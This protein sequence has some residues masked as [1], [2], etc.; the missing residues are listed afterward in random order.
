MHLVNMDVHH[1]RASAPTHLG[2]F[3]PKLNA[4]FGSPGSGKSLLLHW[5]RQ[6]AAAD[7]AAVF[8]HPEH[9]ATATD[10][11]A[12]SAEIVSRGRRYRVS[13]DRPGRPI[14]TQLSSSY[15][16]SH[17]A[18]VDDPRG[19]GSIVGEAEPLS[20][21]QR[22]V[23][24]AVTQAPDY[25]DTEEA[26]ASS[27]QRLQLGVSLPAG[28]H[29]T[30]ADLL[31]RQKQLELLLGQSRLASH[32]SRDGL[33]R[34]KAVLEEEL[35]LALLA[36]SAHPLTRTEAS[37]LDDRSA[38][39]ETELRNAL[40]DVA[41]LARQL[42]DTRAELTALEQ[43][44][45][46]IE[47]SGNFRQQLQQID[48]RLNRWRQTLRELKAQRERIDHQATN[49]R[50]E[51]QIG[52]QLSTG[53]SPDPR[54]SLRTLETQILAAR[55]QLEALADRYSVLQDRPAARQAYDI[56]HDGSGRT[57]ISYAR[58][59]IEESDSLPETLRGMQ[60]SLYE[61]CQQL[62]RHESQAVSETLKQQSQQMQRCES[63]LLQSVEK[64]VEERAELL[65]KIADEY[66]LTGEQMALAFGNWCQ[67][68]DHQHLRHW[69]LQEPAPQ[70]L[71]STV[72]PATRSRLVEKIAEL[73]AR[74]HA[75]SQHAED[76]RR[77]LLTLEVERSKA[78]SRPPVAPS[79][80]TSEVRRELEGVQQELR[81]WD[82]QQ[83]WKAEL[84]S[85]REQ[86]E[87]LR[88]RNTK[89]GSFRDSVK[90][91]IAGL[92]DGAR[93]AFERTQRDGGERRYDLV[94][95]IVYDKV[96]PVEIEV[97]GAIVRLAMRLA[98]VE[99]SAARSEPVP[100]V[101][102]A[103]LDGLSAVVQDSAINHL[104]DIARSGQQLVLLTS[105]RRVANAVHDRLG[106]V[107][108][109]PIRK[110]RGAV[111]VNRHLAALANDYEA[112][113]WYQ[114]QVSPE[115]PRSVPTR[116]EYYLTERSLIEELPARDPTV[117]A[118]CRALGVDRVGDLL[119]ADPHWLAE[120]LRMDG[121]R[122]STVAN[123]QC[124]ASLLCSV[125]HLRPFDARLLVG[126]GVR[127]PRQL[128]E[129]HP[130]E[131]L[132]RVERF[133]ATEPGRR[134]L[135]SGSRYE[136]SRIKAWISSARRGASRYHR[137]SF[138]DEPLDAP[139]DN[140]G[141]SPSAAHGPAADD[142]FRRQRS[143]APA[144]AYFELGD[145]EVDDSDSGYA[146]ERA[147]S[148]VGRNA[149]DPNRRKRSHT[150]GLSAADTGK[151]AKRRR[152]SEVGRDDLKLAR[153]ADRHNSPR[154]RFYLELASPIVDAPSIGP[155]MAARLQKLGLL[156]VEQLLSANPRTLAAK[157]NLRRVD[158][159]T[160]RAWQ[161]QATLVCRIPNLRGHDAQ[162][163]V[164]CDL[165]SPEDLA[166]MIARDVLSQ[167]SQVAESSE[168][169]R[170]LRGG[171][172][173][174]LEEVSDWIAWAANCRTLNAA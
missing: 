83:G 115:T 143:D 146:G 13:L 48:E 17:F 28:M 156:T 157:L 25:P 67:C 94:D 76:C 122:G 3:S 5:L 140:S 160:I 103:P 155:R 133:L 34:R 161:E 151:R 18:Q 38:S 7:G 55:K 126:I 60:R 166:N 62:A 110:T 35:R 172:Q 14:W 12:A 89:V 109:L 137:S 99:F 141:S 43:P 142:G 100:L 1:P 108:Q 149:R 87:E 107:G 165:T 59:A 56:L 173:P 98:M 129:M 53:T 77:Q 20:A 159:E 162:L 123:W 22:E 145:L 171:K 84:R 21:R 91:H 134:I 131:L 163:L 114:P 80:L 81:S 104:S 26:L 44:G 16:E 10:N 136:L 97:P 64:L 167:V 125:R 37:S 4:I 135:R 68:Q 15:V 57:K 121:V 61:A 52:D 46:P 147:Y 73:E 45:A 58:E 33:L 88:K 170:I 54:S 113:K 95:G 148:V 116:G 105:D 29:T 169:Q 41:T 138:N 2:P 19:N 174:D 164:A 24:S 168:G 69:L 75:A 93:Q 130:S 127:A 72:D 8:D 96:A 47:I 152:R 85:I 6:V 82:E 27:A 39:L 102:N 78:N 111:D 153:T 71:Q 74:H 79:R 128:G 63:E 132:E 154:L 150:S 124:E 65:R 9:Y 106:W 117:A 23:L 86:L 158:D 51:Q 112:D 120:H 101:L 49:A 30:K 42:S 92:M 50:L 144:D 31:A 90:R 32:A 139:Y 66:R 119:D 70:A 40:A 118:R 11:L 36:E